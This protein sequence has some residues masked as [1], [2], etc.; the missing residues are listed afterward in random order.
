MVVE[1]KSEN[2]VNAFGVS[3]GHYSEN[4][5]PVTVSLGT[6]SLGSCFAFIR[7]DKDAESVIFAHVSSDGETDTLLNRNFAVSGLLTPANK[8]I[9][10]LYVKGKEPNDNTERRIKS[11]K[12]KYGGAVYQKADY[13]GVALSPFKKA[14]GKIVITHC[15]SITASNN[16]TY[17]TN[18]ETAKLWAGTHG[19]ESM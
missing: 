9:Q 4:Q 6:D 18:T 3:W 15:K 1:Q 5:M 8:E 11:L 2:S 10:Y 13:A 19:L 16:N 14:D 7:V 12:D 17:V